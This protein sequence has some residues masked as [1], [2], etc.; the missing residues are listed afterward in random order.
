MRGSYQK[1]CATYEERRS[2]TSN[3]VLTGNKG[4]D[5]HDTFAQD[6]LD[7][8]SDWRMLRDNHIVPNAEEI[9]ACA[10]GPKKVQAL[11]GDYAVDAILLLLP[12]G[13]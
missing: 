3:L 13:L 1:A 7:G 10:V 5:G 9:S 12:E 6:G 2:D 8:A 4:N 11:H